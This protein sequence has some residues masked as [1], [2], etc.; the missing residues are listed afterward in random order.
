MKLAATLAGVLALAPAS[1]HAFDWYIEAH[2]TTHS[3]QKREVHCFSVRPST[4]KAA[5]P[6][7]VT[8]WSCRVELD[9]VEAWGPLFTQ[10]GVLAC[11]ETATGAEV[12]IVE[13]ALSSLPEGEMA[14]VSIRTK[15]QT[16]DLAL[17]VGKKPT[18]CLPD[19]PFVKRE[20][21]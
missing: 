15:T 3:N 19:L 21:L 20:T 5:V 4:R 14:K 11:V 17:A 7:G 12:T 8:G 13:S 1:A 10:F 9:E 2:V 16:A 6:V 18:G